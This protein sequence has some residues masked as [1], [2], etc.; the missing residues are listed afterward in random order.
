MENNILLD[1]LKKFYENEK[2]LNTLFKISV[3]LFLFL[4]CLFSFLIFLLLD[5][6]RVKKIFLFE[7]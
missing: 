1:Q 7:N 5:N 6:S 3:T 4:N 2:N